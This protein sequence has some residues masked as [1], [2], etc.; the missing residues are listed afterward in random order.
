MQ[1]T[2][3]RTVQP[4]IGLSDAQRQGVSEILTNVLADEFLLYTKTRNYHWNVVGP[5]FSELHAFFE[6]QYQQLNEVVDDTAERIRTF[7]VP[8]IGT[9]SEFLQRSRLKEHPGHYPEAKAMI[10]DLLADHEALIRQLRVDL[11]ACAEEYRDLGAQ[12]FLLDLL[13]RH[14]KMAWML[15]AY[16]EGA[17]V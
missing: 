13:E 14:E 2:G 8:A 10:A 12:D 11:E 17:S 15:R 5:Q 6:D 7:H 3:K 9:L 4:D 1:T 16:L